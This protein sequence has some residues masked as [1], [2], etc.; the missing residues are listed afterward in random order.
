MARRRVP[1]LAGR[2]VILAWERV[3]TV[4]GAR[5]EIPSLRRMRMDLP[6]VSPVHVSAVIPGC[7]AGATVVTTADS[8]ISAGKRERRLMGIEY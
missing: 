5:V 1:E 4:L 3:W 8:A 2:P 6:G 7:W